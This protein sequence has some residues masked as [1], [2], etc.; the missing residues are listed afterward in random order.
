MAT[1]PISP[2]FL[3]QHPSAEYLRKEAK[4]FARTNTM[5]LAAAQRRLA[6]DYG[7]R[8]WAA[9]MIAVQTM[10]STKGGGSG[11]SNSGDSGLS[12]IREPAEDVFPLLPLRGL[13]A[14]PHVSY[15]IFL[16]RPKSIKAAVYAHQHELPVLL[17]AQRSTE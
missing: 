5:Q 16:G 7:Y 15:P 11:A 17:V 4:R 1:T 9:L 6:H 3:P 13:I 10:A 14:F 12:P 2:K 8:N